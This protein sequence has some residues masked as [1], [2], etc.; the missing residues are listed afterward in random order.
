MDDAYSQWERH[1]A[2]LEAELAKRPV[3]CECDQHIQD[4]VCFE[5]NGEY[6][7]K[8]CLVDNHKK[9]TEDCI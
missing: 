9:Y 5:F 6:I 7:C 3:C 1:E 2:K 4:E 8:Q